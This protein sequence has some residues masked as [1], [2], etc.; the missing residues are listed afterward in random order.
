MEKK[1]VI[2][3]KEAASRITD[4]AIGNHI[5]CLCGSQCRFLCHFYSSVLM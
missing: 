1:P 3:D 2:T 5:C 4:G